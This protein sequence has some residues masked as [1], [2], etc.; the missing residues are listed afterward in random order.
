MGRQLRSILPSAARHLRPMT[1][2]P[3]EV[4]SRRQQAQT[5]QK[6]YHDRTA[7]HLPPLQ[8]GDKIYVQ[9]SKGYKWTPAHVIAPSS[10]PRSHRI[11]RYGRQ[12]C[13]LV[14]SAC[15]VWRVIS[16]LDTWISLKSIQSQSSLLP[17]IEYYRVRYDLFRLFSL[18][19]LSPIILRKTTCYSVMFYS[20]VFTN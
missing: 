10:T 8:P 16:P 18:M 12:L 15:W 3:T 9:L 6:M 20:Y 1:V 14:S 5:T 2:N 19:Y 4:I 11:Q 13:K 17:S 7:H